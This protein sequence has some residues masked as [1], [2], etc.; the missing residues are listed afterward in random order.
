MHVASTMN[1]RE[2]DNDVPVI[3]AGT[4]AIVYGVYVNC[5][6]RWQEMYKWRFE[7]KN[8]GKYPTYNKKDPSTIRFKGK[9][10]DNCKGTHSGWTDEGIVLFEEAK[11]E[12]KENRKE[13]MAHIL[14]IENKTKAILQDRYEKVQESK[15]VGD[16][17]GEDYQE[18][19]E[20]H[21][22]RR[23]RNS[24]KSSANKRARV[25]ITL[26]D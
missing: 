25:Q 2:G 1:M 8:T 7:E 21:K 3:P 5:Y 23:E 19:L 26:D 15:A 4:E 20:A 6:T 10:S 17:S 13:N 16:A 18:K 24:R 9:F 12:V 14:E 22:K 11:E